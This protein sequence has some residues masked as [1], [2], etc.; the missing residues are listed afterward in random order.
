VGLRT[1][2]WKDLWR[3]EDT[4]ADNIRRVDIA[5]REWWRMADYKLKGFTEDWLLLRRTGAG[6]PSRVIL[7]L[8]RG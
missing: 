8:L 4:A 2:G 6:I 1:H 7:L 3:G 5:A